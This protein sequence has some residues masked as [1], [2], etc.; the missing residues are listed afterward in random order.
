MLT[1]AH[2]QYGWKHECRMDTCTVCMHV[3]VYSLT[4]TCAFTHT[5]TS[6]LVVCLDLAP[7]SRETNPLRYA[8]PHGF[9][10]WNNERIGPKVWDIQVTVVYTKATAPSLRETFLIRTSHFLAHTREHSHPWPMH[11]KFMWFSSKP[12]VALGLWGQV[13]FTY[14]ET[15]IQ[16]LPVISGP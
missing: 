6:K 11:Y 8:I 15:W 7:S 13:E 9:A 2:V 12:V 16:K 10:L 4:H 5:S 1:K 14:A 3:F